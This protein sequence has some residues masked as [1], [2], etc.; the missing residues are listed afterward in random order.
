MDV[1][2]EYFKG[3]RLAEYFG[4]EIVEVSE[5]SATITMKIDDR[6]MNS[7]GVVHG[8]ATFALADFAFAVSSNSHGT[9][10]LAVTTSLSFLKAVRGGT[11]RAEAREVSL[12]RRLGT[13]AIEVKDDEGDVIGLFQGTAYRKG[14]PIT[15]FIE[16][17][18]QSE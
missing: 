18:R 17:R 13:Y 11:L 14:D 16:A 5:G 10:A 6:H 7:A 4:M 2:R 12:S 8:G 3:D 15:N 1:V 9:L